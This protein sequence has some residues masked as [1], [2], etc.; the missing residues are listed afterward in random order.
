MGADTVATTASVRLRLSPRR[1]LRPEVL[2][3]W[4][5]ELRTWLRTWLLRWIPWLLRRL[6]LR[7]E[8]LRTRLRTWLL[9]WIPW[10]LLGIDLSISAIEKMTCICI[11]GGEDWKLMERL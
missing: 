8:E 7:P 1:R 6:R 3:L 4:S 11:H 2:R 5:E 10:R 9:R